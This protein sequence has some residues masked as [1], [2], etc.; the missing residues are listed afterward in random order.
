MKRP[1]WF[2]PLALGTLAVIVITEGVSLLTVVAIGLLCFGAISSFS[3]GS[4]WESRWDELIR[5]RER[6]G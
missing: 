1:I 3:I 6:N 2:L 5:E 4:R